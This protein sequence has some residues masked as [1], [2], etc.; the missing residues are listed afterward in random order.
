LLNLS[1]YKIILGSKSPRRQELLKG[2]DIDFE[3]RTKNVDESYSES[4]SP[5][6]IPRFLAH[7]KAEAFQDDL[8]EGEILITSDTV[9]AWEDG[10]YNKPQSAVEATEM[11]RQ[12]SGGTHRVITGVCLTAKERQSVF[13]DS[14]TVYFAA[15]SDREIEHYVS[16]YLPFDKAGAYGIQEWIGYIAIEKIDGSF[17]NV[18]GLPT[19]KL[20][21]E[22]KKFTEH[23][24]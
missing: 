9:V 4:L 3:I 21:A 24:A 22:L 1:E 18:M 17:Y 20:Y 11:L 13:H 5:A 19:Q 8:E 16:R 7:K 23:G 2:L 10:I 14:T 15:L 6:E 12:L